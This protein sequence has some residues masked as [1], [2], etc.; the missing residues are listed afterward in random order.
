MKPF[1]LTEGSAD[2]VEAILDYYAQHSPKYAKGLR[3]DLRARFK[4]VGQHPGLG[5][6]VDHVAV[7]LRTTSVRDVTIYF[8]REGDITVIHHVLHGA[9][10][11]DAYFD[12]LGN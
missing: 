3:R 6:P 9:R 2:E 8:R 10:D 11:A 7:G 5:S 4:L 1:R 12:G